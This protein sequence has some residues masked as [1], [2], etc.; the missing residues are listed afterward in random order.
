MQC[1]NR[2]SRSIDTDRHG[3]LNMEKVSKLAEQ[4]ASLRQPDQFIHFKE[5]NHYATE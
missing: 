3:N 5:S 2:R 4:A 1:I